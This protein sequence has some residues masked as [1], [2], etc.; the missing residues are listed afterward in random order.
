M[1]KYHFN[2]QPANKKRTVRILV[3]AGAALIVGV[4]LAIVFGLRAASKKA[5]GDTENCGRGGTKQCVTGTFCDKNSKC[6]PG[7]DSDLDCTMSPFMPQRCDT[8]T[9]QCFGL[10]CRDAT[11]CTGEQQCEARPPATTKV[12]TGVPLPRESATTVRPSESR[13]P[14]Y[15]PAKGLSVT[16][17]IN[18]LLSTGVPAA[19]VVLGF[20]AVGQ[21]LAPVTSDAHDGFGAPY[22][23]TYANAGVGPSFAYRD[24]MYALTDSPSGSLAFIGK[25]LSNMI[26]IV[27][28]DDDQHVVLGTFAYVPSANEAAKKWVTDNAGSGAT[29]GLF[30]SY[31]NKE[32]ARLKTEFALNTALGGVMLY[33]AEGDT[34]SD[35]NL[36][37]LGL[38][39]TIKT[40]VTAAT[41]A[42]ASPFIIAGYFG[43]EEYTRGREC[44]VIAPPGTDLRQMTSTC[45]AGV[46]VPRNVGALAAKCTH[47]HFGHFTISF[48]KPASASETGSFYVDTTDA[49]SD[50]AWTVKGS[51]FP[52]GLQAWTASSAVPPTSSSCISPNAKTAWGACAS[53]GAQKSLT[54][55]DWSCWNA[56]RVGGVDVA[57]GATR[58]CRTGSGFKLGSTG[59]GVPPPFSNAAA[60]G[61]VFG[62]VAS[63]AWLQEKGIK[64]L[65]SIGGWN[66]S[67]YFSAASSSTYVD[68][69]V[70]SVVEWVNVFQFDG[71]DLNWQFPGM[72]KR[73]GV[74]LPN[75]L[76][77]YNRFP[78]GPPDNTKKDRS[79]VT[80]NCAVSTECNYTDRTLDAD[81]LFELVTTLRQKLPAKLIL[82][83][84]ISAEP[85][86]IETLRYGRLAPFVTY[87][88]VLCY[89]FNN[90]K[91][92]LAPRPVTAL[93]SPLT[94]PP[95]TSNADCL[96]GA[97]TESCNRATGKCVQCISNTDCLRSGAL[98]AGHNCDLGT[99]TC[100]CASTT[101]C[102]PGLAC[103]DHKCGV[104]KSDTNCPVGTVCDVEN[105]TCVNCKSDAD[106]VVPVSNACKAGA[107][108]PVGLAMNSPK[109]HVRYPLNGPSAAVEFFTG[110]RYNTADPRNVSDKN[111]EKCC[112]GHPDVM[113]GGLLDGA[114]C[115][116]ETNVGGAVEMPWSATCDNS[117]AVRDYCGSVNPVTKRIMLMEDANCRSW[118]LNSSDGGDSTGTECAAPRLA[119][120]ALMNEFC[121]APAHRD[122]PDCRCINY[123][124]G[125]TYQ[126]FAEQLATLLPGQD[127][128]TQ[129]PVC[130][131]PDCA[132]TNMLD[133]LRSD[134]MEKTWCTCQGRD[135]NIC[136]QIINTNNSTN[137]VINDVDWKQVCPQLPNPMIK[138]DGDDSHAHNGNVC[139]YGAWTCGDPYRYPCTDNAQCSVASGTCVTACSTDAQCENNN[140]CSTQGC[141][142]GGNEAC[143]AGTFCDIATKRCVA[144]CKGCRPGEKCDDGTCRCGGGDG[145][146]C[147][148]IQNC[149]PSTG[150]CEIP[151][152]TCSN[153][154]VCNPATGKCECTAD[155]GTCT[156][157]SVCERQATQGAPSTA[158]CT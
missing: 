68:A 7:C 17:M 24:V 78:D 106:C 152:G 52:P 116:H 36:Y 20:S 87:F 112:S 4:I 141:T 89:N 12:C 110:D 126:K 91:L 44:L 153:G 123:A 149:N 69:F 76:S 99:N 59:V 144:Q 95:C 25:D 121:A 136:Q 28:S 65:A 39:D 96:S 137:V 57:D 63:K 129:N 81:R 151:C 53:E 127:L 43:D 92:G 55:K 108:V 143:G 138:C 32:S 145:P 27:T 2:L 38:L 79:D 88:N 142:C 133:V 14:V 58:T 1:E 42:R 139:L 50:F 82:S 90:S 102:A 11:D 98:V 130:W 109:F 117:A 29:G 49:L 83:L 105:G 120:S 9:N 113:K 41:A 140:Q 6:V 97:G 22:S 85:V 64:V 45:N 48:R 37:P 30:L 115:R 66:D 150:R 124:T 132:G 54:D 18:W 118:C 158:R 33:G 16:S 84:S 156:G 34:D 146:T 74:K 147:S 10:P 21:A 103:I 93:A 80:A 26:H 60:T 114:Q 73:D 3:I 15:V 111:R 70:T 72:E 47:V 155:G 154:N 51:S 86:F 119:C 23:S 71:V 77:G 5:K 135:V 62:G 107:C 100:Y 61:Q 122:S 19:K 134:N 31:E 157:Q 35:Q 75:N 125:E 67:D 131:D 40:A 101:E 94:G 56:Q 104:C 148:S 8:D 128:S 46:G 13:R